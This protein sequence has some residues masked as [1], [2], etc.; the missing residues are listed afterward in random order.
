MSRGSA[1]EVRVSPWDLTTVLN[2]CVWFSVD[3]D[4]IETAV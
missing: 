1:D 4:P 3:G 2:M